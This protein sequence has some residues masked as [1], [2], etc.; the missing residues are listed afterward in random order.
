MW[1][2]G[3]KTLVF[4]LDNIYFDTRN[5]II[6]LLKKD[7]SKITKHV[8]LILKIKKSIETG[9]EVIINDNSIY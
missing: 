2:W 8:L 4:Y 5:T 7:V 9:K 6:T 1:K 3:W